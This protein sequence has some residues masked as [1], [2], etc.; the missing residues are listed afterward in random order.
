TTFLEYA[1]AIIPARLATSSV[2]TCPES[3][4]AERDGLTEICSSGKI[5]LS[6]SE[7]ALTSTSTR[8]SKLRERSNSSQISNDTS[9][10]ERPC[11]RICVGVTTS[12]SA[13]VGSSRKPASAAL[14]Y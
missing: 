3:T 4:M 8:K 9:P 1:S 11:T 10:G 7:A 2:E 6:S 14:W 5:R 13:T 12:A